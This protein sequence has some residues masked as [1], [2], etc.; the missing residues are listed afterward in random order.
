MHVDWLKYEFTVTG[1]NAEDINFNANAC[2][3]AF[4]GDKSYRLD[5][6]VHEDR[7]P[8]DEA[9]YIAHCNASWRKDRIADD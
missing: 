6:E 7:R 9:L 8:A 3:K 4:F 5:I 2:A 1:D